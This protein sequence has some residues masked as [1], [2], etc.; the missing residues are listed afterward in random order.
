MMGQIK[1]PF[2]G[3]KT[4]NVRE[5]CP[6]C[7]KPLYPQNHPG[8]EKD[9]DARAIA[10]RWEPAIEEA[11][12]TGDWSEI[13]AE[14]VR[15]EAANL[16]LSTTDSIPGTR[17]IETREIVSAE[18]VYGMNI[19]RDIFAAVR[20]VFGGRSRAAQKVLRDARRTC[21]TE[22]KREAL[23]AGADAVVGVCLD[24][25]EISGGTRNTML[26]LVATGTAVRTEAVTA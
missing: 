3:T 12:K 23:M 4:A 6:T 10:Q 17:I 9:D 14:V 20:D 13:P 18:C 25:N 21:L 1:C 15:I 22:L 26:F 11:K 2:C 8:A 24:Y 19:F 16:P 5:F 7:E